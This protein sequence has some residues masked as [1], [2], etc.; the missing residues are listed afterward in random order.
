MEIFTVGEPGDGQ[1]LEHS[2]IRECDQPQVWVVRRR[3]TSK[4][5]ERVHH[6][7]HGDSVDGVVA[8][9]RMCHTIHCERGEASVIET[10]DDN[11]RSS[12]AENELSHVGKP[13]AD[14]GAV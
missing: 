4:P 12:R 13:I 9:M 6:G 5:F 7:H 8:E 10:T 1:P 14:R 2:D 11:R 3:G